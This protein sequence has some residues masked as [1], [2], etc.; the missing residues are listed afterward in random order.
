MGLEEYADEGEGLKKSL[1][2]STVRTE[3]EEEEEGKRERRRD[4]RELVHA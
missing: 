3:Q 2:P 1:I 4:K